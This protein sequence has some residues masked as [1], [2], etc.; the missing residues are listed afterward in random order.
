MT[1]VA[2]QGERGAYG[3]EATI[4]Y[5]G[6][7]VD[8]VPCKTFAEVF[9]QVASAQVDRALVPV[10]NSQTGTINDNYDLLR[11]HDLYIIGEVNHPVNHC[12][13]ALPG[14]SL[15]A[16]RRVYSHPQAL[17]QVEVYLRALGV[18]AVAEYD[19]AGSAKII[20]EQGLTGVGAVASARAAQI[21]DLAVLARDIQTIKENI[22]RFAVLG[23][24][25]APRQ[26]GLQKTCLVLT[27]AHLPGALYRC[28]GCLATRSINL[29]KL[30]SRPSRG[31]PFEY[32]FY[33]DFEGHRDDVEVRE[34]LAEMGGLTS[35][36]RVL[37][38]FSRDLGGAPDAG[39]L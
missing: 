27:T 36:L 28:L 18:E 33:M 20:R 10:E 21:Y 30:E 14:Q 25:Q 13:M 9:Q 3:E 31:R 22:T 29:L 38:S 32:V 26:A 23:R 2:F 6:E 34:A 11:Q 12:L 7:T 39:G 17:A 15:A 16:I 24:E 8:V 35:F 37:G 19:T 1:R 5:F 4:R